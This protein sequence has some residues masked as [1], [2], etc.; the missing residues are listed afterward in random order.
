MKRIVNILIILVMTMDM[1]GAVHTVSGQINGHD[2]VDLDLPSGLKWA[3]SNLQDTRPYPMMGTSK[4][5]GATI[6]L[7][8]LNGSENCPY[9]DSITDITMTIEYADLVRFVS[10]WSSTASKEWE[11]S[12]LV[13][14]CLYDDKGAHVDGGVAS[15][16]RFLGINIRAV[17]R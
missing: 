10:L 11:A 1:E 16:P 14:P 4:L 3:T 6:F 12:S 9:V 8:F 13:I 15:E 2:Y 7:P 5:N 17:S